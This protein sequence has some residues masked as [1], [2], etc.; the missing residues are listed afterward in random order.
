MKATLLSLC[1]SSMILLVACVNPKDASDAPQEKASLQE[2][3]TTAQQ[4]NF[5]SFDT[6]EKHKIVS[7]PNNGYINISQVAH[8]DF[9]I[10]TDYHNQH[11]VFKYDLNTHKSTPF[12]KIKS[13]ITPIQEYSH[14]FEKQTYCFCDTYTESQTFGIF[15]SYDYNGN[16]LSEDKIENSEELSDINMTSCIK[17]S[18]DKILI[19]YSEYISN[20]NPENPLIKS[21][22]RYKRPI[23]TIYDLNTK[24]HEILPLRYPKNYS[25]NYDYTGLLEP[26]LID[27]NTLAF[28]FP[29]ND[30]IYIYNIKNKSIQAHLMD[31]KDNF[32]RPYSDFLPSNM[33]HLSKLGT[34]AFYSHLTYLPSNKIYIR[35]QLFIDENFDINL[36]EY[37]YAFYTENFEYI[38]E[39]KLTNHMLFFEDKNN[40]YFLAYDYLNKFSFQKTATKQVEKTTRD[41]SLQDILN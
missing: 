29:A 9:I 37:K 21:K 1:I 41:I 4:I 5:L 17:L 38:G 10:Y 13:R 12:F 19:H 2:I 27:E 23:A 32:I 22:E 26:L 7:T 39:S 24:K 33:E 28:H 34:Y 20:N 8:K 40:L 15:F 16:L 35:E 18:N 30:S 6:L 31:I 36:G 3:K 11:T 14:D 25:N